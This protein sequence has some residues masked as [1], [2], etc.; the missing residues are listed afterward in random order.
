MRRSIQAGVL[1]PAAVIGLALSSCAGSA[2][3][4]RPTTPAVAPPATPAPDTAVTPSTTRT[5]IAAPSKAAT[6]I[7]IK[8]GD[9]GIAGELDDS[10]T[11]ASLIAQLPLTL[12]FR[13]YGGHEKMAELPAALDV[14]VAPAESDAEPLTIGYYAP[15]QRLILYYDYVASFPGIIPIGSYEDTDAIENQTAEFSVTIRQAN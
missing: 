12:S 14:T 5:D 7:V 6:G 2:R 3:E 9:Q 13:D 10:I 15:E 1:V 11:A 8:V 4:N